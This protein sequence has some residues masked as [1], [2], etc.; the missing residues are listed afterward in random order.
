MSQTFWPPE[1][2]LQNQCG[3]KTACDH[4]EM[5]TKKKKVH[6]YTKIVI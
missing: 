1:A 4:F 5:D 2:G 6:N 3:L